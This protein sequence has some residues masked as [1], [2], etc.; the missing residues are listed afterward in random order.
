METVQKV[1]LVPPPFYAKMHKY[2]AIYETL[3]LIFTLHSIPFKK[4]SFLTLRPS[5][6]YVRTVLKKSS[7][8]RKFR[9]IGC[10]VIKTASSYITKYLPISS[11][12]RKSFA[13]DPL[14]IPLYMRKIFFSFLT[15]YNVLPV[16]PVAI[17][18]DFV[19][20]HC[21]VKDMYSYT[22]KCQRSIQ[23]IVYQMQYK[24]TSQKLL[25]L[26][27]YQCS[28]LSINFWASLDIGVSVSIP[29]A[30]PCICVFC[31]QQPHSR[32]ILQGI[33]KLF[34]G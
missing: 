30:S 13:P 5:F 21:T 3:H 17:F 34:R 18:C 28:Y 20:V 8:I 29:F 23:H 25:I 27:V 1:L 32:N 6:L 7:Y 26:S 31:C 11:Y 14:W 12:I 16:K 2:L 24:I 9:R 22:H 10:K 4:T 19:Y 33:S 15:V